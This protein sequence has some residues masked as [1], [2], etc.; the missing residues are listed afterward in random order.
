MLLFWVFLHEWIQVSTIQS[1][2]EE[3]GERDSFILNENLIS[4]NDIDTFSRRQEMRI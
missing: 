1:S 2:S 4:L 3:T